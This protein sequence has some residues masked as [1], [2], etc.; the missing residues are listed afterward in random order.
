MN[1]LIVTRHKPLVQ[2]L[3][4]RGIVGQVIEQAG[5]DD[6][7]GKHVFG[8]LPMW[9]AAHALSITEVSMPRITVEDR[10][11]VAGGDFTVEEMDAWGAHMQ[12]FRVEQFETPEEL[13]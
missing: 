11:R 2:W 6:V 3:A 4:N 9:L 10:R 5:P 12:T 7:R 1:I 8:V 13:K